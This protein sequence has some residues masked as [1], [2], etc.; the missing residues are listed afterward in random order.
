MVKIGV[1]GCGFMG[2]THLS[3]YQLLKDKDVSI[4]AVADIDKAKAEKFAEKLG[5]KV[6]TSGKELIENADVNT[7]DICLPTYMHYEY[8]CMAVEKGYNVFVEKPLCRTSKQAASLA[9]LAQEKNVLAMVGQ[10]LRFWDEYT[11]LKDIIDKKTYGNVIYANFRRFSNRP[12]WGWENWLMDN[13]KSGGAALDLHVHDVDFML[14]A[15]GQPKKVK[16]ITNK[17][18]EKNSTVLSICS[19]DNFTVSLE[20]GWDYPKDYPFQM[21]YKVIFEKAVVEFSGGVKVYTADGVFDAEIKKESTA[22]SE[23]LGG[24]ISDLGGYYNELSYFVNC[25]KNNN[26]PQRATL[27]DG[28]ASVKFVEKELSKIL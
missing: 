26:K 22:K 23:G 4:T 7:V 20:G 14:Y 27:S 11:Y 24:N 28:A 6:Y 18:G 5:A 1:I 8:A 13:F 15:F 2:G 10:C 9:K 16:T 19:Y 17:A 3:A 12:V 21:T 25:L